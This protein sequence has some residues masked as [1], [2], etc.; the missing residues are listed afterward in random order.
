MKKL[1]KENEKVSNWLISK[2]SD[3]EENNPDLD[4][5]ESRE[6]EIEIEFESN[7][8][9]SKVLERRL[10]RDE[11]ME[12]WWST[13]MCREI[14]L[15]LIRDVPGSALVDEILNRV[16]QQSRKNVSR[17]QAEERLLVRRLVSGLADSIPGLSATNSIMEEVL[18]M[19][20][21]R[22]GVN[23][24]RA[25][26]E[27][28]KRM[29]RLIEWRIYALR[30]DER[31]LLE[32]IEKEER[33]ERYKKLKTAWPQREGYR[34]GLVCRRRLHGSRLAGEG[35]PG[36]CLPD[37]PDGEIGVGLRG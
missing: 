25:N 3:M 21:W 1:A 12:S 28:D 30:M 7:K 26:L 6:M 17:R 29:Q 27:G 19:T 22:A 14:L 16:A 36:A 35:D 37:R 33:L 11:Q 13:K 34:D 24:V 23:E 20:V 32:S 10:K 2:H 8:P 31:L 5:E 15:G 18:G 9:N 4:M